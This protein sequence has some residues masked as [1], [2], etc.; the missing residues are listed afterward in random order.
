MKAGKQ[1]GVVF[2]NGDSSIVLFNQG[3]TTLIPAEDIPKLIAELTALLPL[4]RKDI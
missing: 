2:H 1:I 4:I 3:K